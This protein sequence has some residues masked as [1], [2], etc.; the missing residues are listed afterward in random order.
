MPAQMKQL[1]TLS[2]VLLSSAVL[3]QS[4]KPEFDEITPDKGNLNAAKYVAI[5]NSITAGYADNGLYYKGQQVSYA[6]LL[7]QQLMLVGGGEFKMPYV[8]E[9]SVGI[10]GSLNAPLKLGYATDC[11]GITGLAPVPVAASGDINI[12]LSSIAANGPYNCVGVPGARAIE[13]IFPGY[14]NPANGPGLYNPFFTRY[15]ND[16]V[17]SSMLSYAAGQNPTFFSLFIGNNDVLG[18]ALSG[19]TTG[20]VTPSAGPAGVG[21]DASIDLTVNTMTAN[22][23]QG[24]I[25]NVPDITSI[26]YFTTV[27]WNGLTLDATS[28][29]MLTAAYAALGI[30]FTA[31]ANGFIIEDA[32][33]PAGFRQI[34]Q[35]ELVLLS[36]PQDSLKC[37]GW[38]S[39]R[40]IPDRY[41]LDASEIAPINAAVAAYNVKLR[42]VADAKGLAFVDVNAFLGAARTSIVYN[43]VE[44]TTTFVSGGGFSLDGVHLTPR[45][46]ALLCNEFIKAINLKYNS[47]IPQVDATKYTGV[48][49]PAN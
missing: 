5:G 7:A 28:A 17:N 34:Q 23:A 18:Y 16:P 32:A 13:V 4:C 37:A 42:N 25:G 31:G 48:V 26:P 44:V 38:G 2:L 11:R 40:P 41:V 33:A 6:N 29:S 30:T 1:K 8:P 46:N 45:G 36:V 3:V 12:F 19:G 39:T 47:T 27:P 20:A 10:G 9:T 35:G 21:F 24:V 49:F 43:G 22:G 15:T 14:G